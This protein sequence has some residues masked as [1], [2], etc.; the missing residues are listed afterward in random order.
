MSEEVKKQDLME[1]DPFAIFGTKVEDVTSYEERESRDWSKTYLE[2]DPEKGA[3]TVLVKLC[4]NVF[5]PKDPL[6]KRYTYKLP[7]PDN[8][9]RTYTFLSPSTVGKPCPVMQLFWD[10][11]AAA[12]KGDATADAKKKNLSR[13]RN[14]AVMVQ[15]INDLKNPAMNGQFRILRFPEGMELDKVIAAKL[16]P[17]EDDRKM[18]A[19]AVNVFDPVCSPLLILKCEKGQYGRDFSK[20]SWAPDKNNHGN[21]VPAKVD[22]NGNI[23]EYRM[24]TEADRQSPELRKH[25]TWLVEQ[26]KEPE[27]SLKEQWLYKDP[28][29][30]ELERVKQSLELISTGKVTAKKDDGTQKLGADAQPAAAAT[31]A[32]TTESATVS[33][34]KT[35]AT[36]QAQPAV[37]APKS[38][39]ASDDAALMKELG[40]D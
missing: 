30:E 6:P 8:A 28:T 39:A 32:S 34:E 9:D 14:R 27:V 37:E 5:D 33:A 22:E 21:M 10:L 38:A 4:T 24:L 15:I 7:Y 18:G 36:T 13:K 40:L 16:N 31:P 20:S 17:S 11:N 25:L 2:L 23:L 35:E 12:K 1:E 29:E 19:E 26:L 3:V